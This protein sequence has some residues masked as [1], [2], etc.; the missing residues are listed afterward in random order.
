MTITKV[1]TAKLQQ[2]IKEFGSLQEAIDKLTMQKMAT[3]AKLLAL[4]KEIND[5]E[6][7]SEELNI[8][9]EGLKDTILLK[10]QDV[11]YLQ[12]TIADDKKQ[13]EEYRQSI[14]QFL[15]QYRLFES[16]VAILQTSPLGGKSIKDLATEIL[17][18]GEATWAFS[19]P[20]EKLRWLFIYTVLGKHLHCYSCTNCKAKFIVNK[21]PRSDILGYSCPICGLSFSVRADPSF[22]EAMLESGSNPDLA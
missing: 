18:I 17:M 22:L 4:A 13:V 1:N 6:N 10:K 9:I 16:F 5:K 8:E 11:V 2:A 3:E 15:Y 21:E 19:E 14:S 7:K 12:K 20:S